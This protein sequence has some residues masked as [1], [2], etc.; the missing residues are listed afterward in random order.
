[1]P[2]G[3]QASVGQVTFRVTVVVA[4]PVAPLLIV[5][6][7]PAGAVVSTVAVPAVE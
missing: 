7:A 3:D 6:A 4:V 2:T 5:K 1:M